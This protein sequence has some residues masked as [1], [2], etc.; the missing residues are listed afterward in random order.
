MPEH[1]DVLVVGGGV[2]G[3][4]TAYSLAERGANVRL[5]ERGQICSGCS[6]G[7]AGWIA[8]SHSVP[9]PAPGVIGHALDWLTDPASPFYIKL[10]PSTELARWLWRFR[11]ACGRS[12]MLESTRL[13]RELSLA[14]RERYAKLASL[15]GLAFGYQ[16]HGVL[17]AFRTGAGLSEALQE[18]PILADLGG[19]GERLSAQQLVERVPLLSTDLAGGIY[20]PDDAHITPG[21]FVRGLAG[22]ASRLGAAIHTETEV[23][24]IEPQRGGP[25][26]VS[27]TRGEFRCDELVLAAGAW[28][29]TLARPLQLRLPVQPAKGYSIGLPRPAEFG[30]HPVMLGEARVAVTPMGHQLRLEGTL[31]LAGLDLRVNRRRVRSIERGARAFL[32]GL[33]PSEP[34]EIW[35]GL[36]PLTPDDLPIIGRPAGRAGLVLATGHGM[37]GMSQG[38]ITGELVAQLLSGEPPAI[39]VKPFSPD[40]FA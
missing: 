33:P 27:T 20:L 4:C 1:S 25:T 23:L 5:V 15:P 16:Q 10:R 38:P 22:E 34:L 18:L 9:L 28:C 14:S 30:E 11:A 31:E 32:P 40:R 6:H 17:L 35:R 37:M 8:P 29:P 7:N 19:R 36:R 12:T 3:V 39:D 26:R 2:I 24:E 21:D 13:R